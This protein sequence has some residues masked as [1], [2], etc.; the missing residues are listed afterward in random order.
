LKTLQKSLRKRLTKEEFAVF[1]IFSN[2][3][4]RF[5]AVGRVSKRIFFAFSR[6][7]KRFSFVDAL[8]CID[9]Y[10]G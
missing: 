9:D 6:S 2:P 10:Y 3:Q 8:L 5:T 4:A 1:I 7:S